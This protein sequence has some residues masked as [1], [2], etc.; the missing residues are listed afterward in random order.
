MASFSHIPAPPLSEF[1]DLLWLYEGYQQPHKKERLLPDGS[2]ELVV[3]LKED[4]TRVYDPRDPEKCTTFRGTSVAGA[5]SEFF[6]IDTAEQ[7]SVAGV[8]FKPG[9]AFP[10]FDLPANEL[11]NQLVSLDDLWGGLAAEL[12]ERLLEAPAPQ[13]KFRCA[14]RRPAHARG[15]PAP[16][17]SGGGL[18]LAAVSRFSSYPNRCRR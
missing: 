17:A 14:G 4:R 6:V 16:S 1:V 13:G 9:G 5:H 8:H 2:M 15:Q 18:R 12:R 11:H 3:N 7:H 10:F